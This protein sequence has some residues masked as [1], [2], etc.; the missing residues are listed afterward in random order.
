MASLEERVRVG[1]NRRC[2]EAEGIVMNYLSK[3]LDTRLGVDGW[4]EH[5]GPYLD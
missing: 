2:E 4:E 5:F 3:N 1:R